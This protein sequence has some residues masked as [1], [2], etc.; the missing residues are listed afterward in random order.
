LD[1]I[2]IYAHK[3][4]DLNNIFVK[5]QKKNPNNYIELIE[6]YSPY[7]SSNLSLVQDISFSDIM[8]NLKSNPEVTKSTTN[9]MKYLRAAKKQVSTL[10]ALKDITGEWDTLT[11]MRN[12]SIFADY[13]VDI[14]LNMLIKEAFQEGKITSP[15]LNKSGISVIAIGKL[16]SQ[17]LNYSSDID[18]IF[19]YDISKN[20]LV[21]RSEIVE[22]YNLIAEKL[23][24]ILNKLTT[25]GY[26]FRVDTKI[27]PDPTI[28]TI[29]VDI[30]FA[31]NYYKRFA[32][33]WEKTTMLK[34][35]H[36]SGDYSVGRDFLKFID[37]WIWNKIPDSNEILNLTA[38]QEYNA[39]KENDEYIDIK[40]NH[41]CIRDIELFVKTNQIINSTPDNK[42]KTSNTVTAIKDLYN[43]NIISQDD[44]EKL[45]NIYL[46]LRDIEHRMQ[47]REDKQA[48]RIYKDKDSI[49][50]L[51]LFMGYNN[52]SDFI[53][54]FDA[55]RT[56]I[57]EIFK[58]P[59]CSKTKIVKAKQDFIFSGLNDNEGTIDTLSKLGFR[60]PKRIT[61]AVRN[62]LYGR[63][64]ITGNEQA[65]YKIIETL[66]ILLKSMSKTFNPDNAFK[67]F[68]KLIKNMPEGLP[69]FSLFIKRNDHMHVITKIL[70]S[71][72]AIAEYMCNNPK[73]IN[74]VISK[75]YQRTMQ[76]Y[77]ELNYELTFE[78]NKSSDYKDKIKILKNF[79]NNKKFHTCV[80]VL[81]NFSTIEYA[82]KYLSDIAEIA[83]KSIL[84][85]IHEDF[86]K[87]YGKIEDS[88]FA[89]IA[90]G[91][92]GA[93]YFTPNSDLDFI[94]IYNL[95]GYSLKS[96]GD[97]SLYSDE[98]YTKFMQKIITDISTS[99]IYEID[100]RIRPEGDKGPIASSLSNFIKYQ[101]EHEDSWEYMSVVKGIII[102]KDEKIK[103]LIKH[104]IGKIIST[105]KDENLLKN[106]ML[107]Q[108]NEIKE[109]FPARSIWD[110]KYIDGGL[111]DISFII[112]YLTL[113]SESIDTNQNSPVKAL[114][115][116]IEHKVIKEKDAKKLIETYLLLQRL[117]F[118]LKMLGCFPLIPQDLS[119]Q[120]KKIICEHIMEDKNSYS[121][122]KLEEK[123]IHSIAH[124][125]SIYDELFALN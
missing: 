107:K 12:L 16:G 109:R 69:I 52:G 30:D 77:D 112:K 26:V 10:T 57:K 90:I 108:R 36:I 3:D 88:E 21:R 76:S 35:R 115:K 33:S 8:Y 83:I 29:A 53:N 28:T 49:E 84:P 45:A 124:T 71:S 23:S 101:L 95:D 42:I 2:A 32:Q 85:Y 54:Y 104:E 22:H 15:D 4:R 102:S 110:I 65:K 1:I 91:S 43:A 80:R 5:Y 34:A 41:Y 75:D 64:D 9:L 55:A 62:W 68:D 116:L 111:L 46:Y 120:A 37:N 31:E 13:C 117:N 72:D 17:E 59:V 50:E 89:L 73:V 47:M 70:G 11:A 99:G 20:N 14:T 78:L 96:D 123:I 48:Y 51:A 6:K 27:R 94:P 121:I 118:F 86:E 98:Y 38:V 93:K 24:D 40:H 19:I 67:Y 44:S 7:V 125:Q 81:L 63:Y 103:R 100:P 61:S 58:K 18:L 119:E 87:I 60:H 66:P 105:P 122:D 113:K 79:V 74:E 25:D 92:L 114:E 106:Y 56:E 39:V 97:I 82:S